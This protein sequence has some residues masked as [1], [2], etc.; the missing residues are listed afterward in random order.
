MVAGFFIVSYIGLRLL[1]GSSYSSRRDDDG[2]DRRG[3]NPI[4]VVALIFLVAGS[5]TWFFGSILQ[6]M[7]SR[8]RE[9][10]ADACS[11]QYTRNPEGIASAL[12]KIASSNVSDMPRSG[13]P[14]AHLYLNQHPS[15]W[16]QLFATHPPLEKRISAIEGGAYKTEV[17]IFPTNKSIPPPFS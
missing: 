2:G 1:Q 5:I 8:Q 10:L 6:A 17:P 15:F 12:K 14:F 11:V 16:S 3:G 4:V 13:Q 7:V 9:Y